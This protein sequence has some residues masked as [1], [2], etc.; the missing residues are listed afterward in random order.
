[1]NLYNIK[2]PTKSFTLESTYLSIKEIFTIEGWYYINCK[3]ENNGSIIEF[4]EIYYISPN[5]RPLCYKSDNDIQYY[6][7]YFEC[8]FSS[9]EE[10]ERAW[11]LKA[12][13]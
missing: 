7:E 12:F 4:N 3:Y 6:S 2:T 5:I 1:M 11:E 13:A 8:Y 9:K 10:F